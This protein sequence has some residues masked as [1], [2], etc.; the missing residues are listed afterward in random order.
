MTESTVERPTYGNWIGQRSP[1]LFGA[2]L[3]GTAIMFAGIIFSLVGLLAGGWRA[4][5]IVLA[6]SG[7]GFT[8]VG[9]PVG[10]WTF[11]RFVF[12]R[13]KGAGET[14]WKSGM[15][16]TTR[17]LQSR[18]PGM[19]ARTELLDP[20]DT[21]GSRFGVIKSAAN[22][23]TIVARCS[24]DGPWMQDQERINAWVANYAHVLNACGQEQGMVCVKVITD[25]APD[26][27]GRL[28]AMVESLRVDTGPG[29]ARN[30]I[31]ECVADLPAASS[32]NVTY[33]ELTYK[34]RLIN[35][36]NDQTAIVTE[37]A[38]KVPGLVNMLEGAG[39]GAV[40]MVSADELA[41]IV[42]VA[43]DPAM[44]ATM[45][46]DELRGAADRI[47]WS[48]AGPVATS[49]R[50]ADFFHDSGHSISWEMVGAPRS[51]ITEMALA[52]FVAPHH[53]FARKRVAM[54]YRPH[55]PDEAAR[56]AER[57]AST[58]N[59]LAQQN[60]KKRPSASAQLIQRAAEQSRHEVASGAGSVRFS[61]MFTTTSLQSDDVAQ[62][63]STVEARAGAV[64]IR[65][66]RCYGSQ[67][68]AFATTLPVGFVPWEHT[69]ISS[70][71]REWL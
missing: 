30:I 50:W 40:E 44:Q 6:L 2:G 38:R 27:G 15:F 55:S 65:V 36:K 60:G 42:R 49:E 58:A 59:F 56:V 48:E 26:P 62:A 67:A 7:I 69:A 47:A 54:I 63:V 20:H 12:L 1:G 11:R 21:F 68:A 24:A 53:D 33:V 23:Y 57:D 51:R 4:A 14:R 41:R 3:I 37:L 17:H 70:N 66:R 32:E 13:S 8:A 39:G 19:L 25:T 43:Y 31:D 29:L 28:T 10:A 5:L 61:L 35:R 52:G 34:G 9:T 46:R 22:L 16:A 64:P 45:E 71:V 18:L